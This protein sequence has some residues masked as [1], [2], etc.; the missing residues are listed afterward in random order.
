MEVIKFILIVVLIYYS[1]KII[2]RLLFPIM[3]SFF[4]KKII[5]KAGDNFY[6][7]SNFYNKNSTEDN[8]KPKEKEIKII[9]TNNHKNES[10]FKDSDDE[11]VDF[12]EIK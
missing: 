6:N 1:L 7:Y 8:Y 9:N 5:K 3:L 11:Y 10:N 2:I 12:E 4:I